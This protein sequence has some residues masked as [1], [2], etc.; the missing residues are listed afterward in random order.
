MLSE[1]RMI[2]EENSQ[3]HNE[4]SILEL[5]IHEFILIH[6]PMQTIVMQ[7]SNH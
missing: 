3:T 1:W 5:K 4:V 2:F 6:F 7:N